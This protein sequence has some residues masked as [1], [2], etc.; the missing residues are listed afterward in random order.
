M[1]SRQPLGLAACIPERSMSIKETGYTG[2]E[3][4]EE[5]S[6]YDR[7]LSA[8]RLLG[9]DDHRSQIEAAQQ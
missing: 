4:P 1:G 3:E 7:R 8:F 5:P 2:G 6:P 9:L